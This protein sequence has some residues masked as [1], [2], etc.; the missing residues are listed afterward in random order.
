[1]ADIKQSIQFAKDNPDSSFAGELRKR[2]ESGSLNK[3]LISAGLR[4]AEPKKPQKPSFGQRVKSKLE[5][6]AVDVFRG[7]ERAIEGEISPVRGAVRQLGAIAGAGVDI[8]GEAFSSL[9][10]KTF[11][12]LPEF[13]QKR[14][15]ENAQG[16]IQSPG[17]QMAIKAIR[18]G[19][20]KFAEFE[21][22]NP[23]LARDLRDLTNIA[24]LAVTF[25]GVGLAKESFKKAPKIIKEVAEEVV[26]KAPRIF[27]KVS[28]GVKRDIFEVKEA[29]KLKGVEKELVEI[30]DLISP[31]LTRTELGRASKEG[32]IVR[33]KK[34]RIFGDK[35]D[36]IR[37]TEGVK[38]ASDTIQRRIK[39]ASKMN[40]QELSRSLNT[41]VGLI[42]ENIKPDM[43]KVKVDTKKVKEVNDTWNKFKAKQIQDPDFDEFG[44]KK[45][46]QNFETRL[47]QIADADNLDEL[48]D[49]R[50]DYDKSIANRIKEADSNSE[51]RLQFQKDTWLS[52]RAILN[53]AINDTAD[54]LGGTSKQ[55][56]SD[57][58]DLYTG[59]QNI[60]SKTKISK[61]KK[62]VFSQENLI[63]F[64]G[65]WIGGNIIEKATGINIPFI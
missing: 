47:T 60:A 49:I 3:E 22:N 9:A 29:R 14:L 39:G 17:G 26:E 18:A 36:E 65:I 23:E 28:K 43:K 35:P 56:F 62:G 19:T 1:M 58:S 52:N 24:D 33:G 7:T 2:I 48:W 25:T 27:E 37:Q 15:R 32:R 4:K 46:Q 42:S 45:M 30:E 12:N 44:G 20:D 21:E 40:D 6:R 61:P 50:K 55:A 53:D 54:G 59:I 16:L 57:M 63:K 13:Q 11:E 38:K 51:G 41:N 64:G 31:K 8:V 34:S 5:K 10:S